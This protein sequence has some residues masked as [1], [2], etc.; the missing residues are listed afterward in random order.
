MSD[1]FML[2]VIAM[3]FLVGKIYLYMREIYD[4]NSSGNEGAERKVREKFC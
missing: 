3:C 4:V 1:A 2:R